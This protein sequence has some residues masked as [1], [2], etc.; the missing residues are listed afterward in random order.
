[1]SQQNFAADYINVAQRIAAFHEKYP[2]G[3][4]QSE[5]LTLND[6][7]VL[8]RAQ[9]FR[10]PEDPRPGIGHAREPIPGSTPYTRGSEVEN[11]ETSAWGRAIAALGFEVKAGIATAED[12]RN[13]QARQPAQDAPQRPQ[14]PAPQSQ[15]APQRPA[16]QRTSDAP[17]T[18]AGGIT[19]G[20]ALEA[21]KGAGI[22]AKTISAKGKELYGQWSLKEMTPEQ[23]AHVVE[24]L[25][26][27]GRAPAPPT[28]APADD[29]WDGVEV[30]A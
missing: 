3:S 21:L 7:E 29:M 11:A 6:H 26:G 23:R 1:M 30:A 19:L 16:P 2:E 25:V 28:N 22:D 20:Q 15:P 24:E 5:I 12:V 10:T 18:T 8:I 9:A 4:L 17:R 13:A 14:R 27:G